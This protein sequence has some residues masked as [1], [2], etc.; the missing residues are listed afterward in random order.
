MAVLILLFGEKKISKPKILMLQKIEIRP[1]K[2]KV[3]ILTFFQ[4]LITN[5]VFISLSGYF[6]W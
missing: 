3:G 5:P 4:A 2:P 6:M 1:I